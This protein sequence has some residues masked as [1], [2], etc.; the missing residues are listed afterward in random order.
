MPAQD[1]DHRLR[2]DTGGERDHRSADPIH[3]TMRRR[4]M[5][6]FV[7]L[8]VVV[9]LMQEAGKPERWLWMGFEQPAAEQTRPGDLVV[10]ELSPADSGGQFPDAETPVP[11]AALTRP[12]DGRREPVETSPGILT[13][14]DASDLP[15]A[16]KVFWVDAWQAMN[17]DQKKLTLGLLR[18]SRHPDQPSPETVDA[19]KDLLDWLGQRQASAETELLNQ[20]SLLSEG[21]DEKQ[22]RLEELYQFQTLFND[23]ARPAFDSLTAGEDITLNQQKQLM[24][25]QSLLDP[26]IL[27]DVNDFSA[28]GATGDSVAWMRMWEQIRDEKVPA[29]DIATIQLLAQPAAWRGQPVRIEGQLRTARYRELADSA[30]GLQG[31]YELWLTP[32][33][34]PDSLTCIYALDKPASFPSIGNRHQAFDRPVNLVGRFFKIRAYR[35]GDGSAEHCPLVLAADFDWQPPVKPATS[36]ISASTISPLAIGSVL[37]IISIVATAIAWIVYRTSRQQTYQPRGRVADR[38][39]QSLTELGKDPGIQTEAERIRELYDEA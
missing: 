31:W 24:R 20:I 38:I 19:R 14:D 21:S 17:V 2:F 27:N 1:P 30:I 15:A 7:M 3:R 26:L 5:M 22:E 39:G 11:R 36:S 37:A 9:V 32:R 8:V 10:A 18:Q 33:D 25:L 13:D 12:G 16:T 4:L 28:V 29:D 35:G 6:L 23:A 34:D